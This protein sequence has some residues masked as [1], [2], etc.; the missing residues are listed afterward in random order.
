M[1][2]EPRIVAHR[3][4]V[5]WT[6]I[7]NAVKIMLDESISANQGRWM[8]GRRNRIQRS[9]SWIGKRVVVIDD[10]V[11]FDKIFIQVAAVLTAWFGCSVCNTDVGP[12]HVV[13]FVNQI[14]TMLKSFVN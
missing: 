12:Q 8:V 10:A 4:N 6:R 9:A 3:I 13:V 7:K 5:I 11:H 2:G 1:C 14:V